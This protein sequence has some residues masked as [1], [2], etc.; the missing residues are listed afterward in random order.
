MPAPLG[1][2]IYRPKA[3]RP[4]SGP[5]LKEIGKKRIGPK[6]PPE[7]IERCLTCTL[8]EQYCTGAADCRAGRRWL[9]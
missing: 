5:T 7:M 8:P 6:D 9:R 3:S 1:K 2:H 4:G